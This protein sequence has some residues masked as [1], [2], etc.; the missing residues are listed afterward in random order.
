MEFGIKSTPYCF[1]KEGY[2]LKESV[3]MLD[4]TFGKIFRSFPW[5]P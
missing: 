2:N 1:F 4:E 5:S 3:L